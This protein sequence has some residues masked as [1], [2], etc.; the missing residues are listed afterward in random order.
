MSSWWERNPQQLQAAR[1][2]SQPLPNAGRPPTQWGVPI[3][4]KTYDPGMP[5]RAAQV[6]SQIAFG[7]ERQSVSGGQAGLGERFVRDWVLSE[8]EF[9][10]SGRQFAGGNVGAG[11]GWGVLGLAGAIPLFGDAAQGLVRASRAGEQIANVSRSGRPF[12]PGVQP[13]SSPVPGYTPARG[14]DLSDTFGSIPD[15]RFDDM[16]GTQKREFAERVLD[17]QGFTGKPQLIPESAAAGLR[18]ST[19]YLP[20]FRGIKDAP[21]T[22]TAHQFARQFADGSFYTMDGLFGTGSYWGDIGTAGAYANYGYRTSQEPLGLVVEA[23]LPRNA[24]I[25][26]SQSPEWV[27]G[28]F[29]RG[30]RDSNLYD[31]GAY[32]ASLGY[33]AIRLHSGG[34]EGVYN[35]LNRS[36]LIVADTAIGPRGFGSGGGLLIDEVYGTLARSNALERVPLTGLSTYA[37]PPPPTRATSS[38]AWGERPTSGWGSQ[39]FSSRPPNLPA[40]LP[41]VPPTAR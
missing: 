4:P 12:A 38:S 8:Q 26:T 24:K 25:L 35:I 31:M 18:D 17:A 21:E 6:A 2:F 40:T 7:P 19:D 20:V 32:A 27:S 28:E 22:G 14:A 23:F 41:F 13:L 9:K 30:L 5:Q 3:Q 29:V 36:A 11:L 16:L 34:T 15:V 33:D 39:S 1:N 10:E 37:S